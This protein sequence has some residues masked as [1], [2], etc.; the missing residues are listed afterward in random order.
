MEFGAINLIIIIVG[1]LVCFT[2][3]I[4]KKLF[5]AIL[6][7]IWGFSSAYIIMMLMALAGAS[8][9]RNMNEATTIATLLIV[10]IL[11]AIV[12]VWLEQLLI[13]IHSVVISFVILFLLFGMLFQ[14]EEFSAA[15]IIALIIAVLIG[16]AMWKY[17]KYAFIIETAITGSIMINHMWL[18]DSSSGSHS[19]RNMGSSINEGAVFLTI[20]IA[21]AGILVQSNILKRMENMTESGSLSA[22]AGMNISINP[23]EFL[24]E[25][26]GRVS[27]SVAIRDLLSEKL[28]LFI[29]LFGFVVSP[30]LDSHSYEF[31]YPAYQWITQG[32][33]ILE[34][35]AY[36]GILYFAFQKSAVS[37]FVYCLPAV[38]VRI[39]TEWISWPITTLSTT[40]LIAG[41]LVIL[42]MCLLLR[43][44]MHA[45]YK[46]FCSILFII[47]YKCFLYSWVSNRQIVW[48]V[49]SL[50]YLPILCMVVSITIIMKVKCNINI[51]NKYIIAFLAAAAVCFGVYKY[52]D[53]KQTYQDSA[54]GQYDDSDSDTVKVEESAFTPEQLAL[55]T[56]GSWQLYGTVACDTGE[57]VLP[58]DIFYWSL[59]YFNELTFDTEGNFKIA[60]G[61]VYDFSGK[62]KFEGD[63]IVL[64]SDTTSDI[65]SMEFGTYTTWNGMEADSL[66]WEYEDD[67]GKK[68]LV[69]MSKPE[70]FTE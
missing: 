67:E 30:I 70:L 40:V 16:I 42:G 45:D 11:M 27:N 47:F 19:L 62:Y 58:M 50:Y 8:Q 17:Y 31:S 15:L 3:I 18:M 65:I 35:V 6:G 54:L 48:P 60:L 63:S 29:A 33:D 68:Y 24:K 37:G 9:I 59:R 7:F 28:W 55:L 56:D 26:W 5:E 4:F 52:M 12:T 23:K 57:E 13:T 32:C 20:L 21:I 22:E 36:G 44:V 25:T 61:A 49:M 43:K 14:N 51:F 2:A 41:P 64:Y 10:G 34:M 38:I 1:I 69:Y 66:V 39:Y 53:D 46:Y